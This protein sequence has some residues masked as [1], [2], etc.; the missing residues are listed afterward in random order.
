[1][2]GIS[3]GALTH[4]FPTRKDMLE[5]AYEYIVD[6][7]R[8]S[9]PFSKVQ[10]GAV[11]SVGEMIDGLWTLIYE[12]PWYVATM[13][14]M[15]ASGKDSELGQRLRSHSKTWIAERDPAAMRLLGF[16]DDNAAAL[17]FFTLLLSS[18]RGIALS[19]VLDADEARAQKQLRNC[20][21]IAERVVA[22]LR[23]PG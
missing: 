3:R 8:H 10:D 13:E 19:R 4:Q 22:S 23:S 20:K 12:P 6:S 9:F 18:L 15:I 2:A 1:M 7:W 14:L 11:L 5:A 21:V 16:A 17:D